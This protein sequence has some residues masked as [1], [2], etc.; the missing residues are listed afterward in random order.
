MFVLGTSFVPDSHDSFMYM[1]SG[2]RLILWKRDFAVL[3]KF[4]TLA[5]WK[6]QKKKKKKKKQGQ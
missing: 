1:C 2:N 5:S 6:S 4:T 3:F